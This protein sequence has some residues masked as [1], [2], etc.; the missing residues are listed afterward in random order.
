MTFRAERF[1]WDDD[2]ELVWHPAPKP[3]PKPE[4]PKQPTPK[5]ES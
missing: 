5:K 1:H 3:K 2:A 4:P